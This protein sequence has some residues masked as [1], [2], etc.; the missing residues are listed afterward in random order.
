[1]PESVCLVELEEK[2]RKEKKLFGHANFNCKKCGTGAVKEKRVY[3]PSKR[4]G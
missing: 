4:I 2:K 1:M 3:K